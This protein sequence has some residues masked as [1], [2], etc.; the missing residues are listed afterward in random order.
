MCQT[1]DPPAKCDPPFVHDSDDVIMMGM[2]QKSK[3]GVQINDWALILTV[4]S[5]I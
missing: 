2:A 5:I 3:I 4:V 1:Q